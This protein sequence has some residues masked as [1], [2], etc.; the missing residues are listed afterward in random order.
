M[1]QRQTRDKTS[2]YYSWY[3]QDKSSQYMGI[4]SVK[5]LQLICLSRRIL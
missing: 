3:L 2:I 5:S 4:M 1:A